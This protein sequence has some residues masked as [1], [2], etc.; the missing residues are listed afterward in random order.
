[1]KYEIKCLL[2][3]FLKDRQF[4]ESSIIA[5]SMEFQSLGPNA[6]TCRFIILVLANGMWSFDAERV[7]WSCTV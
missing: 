2:Y 3:R 7:E 1:M 5:E 6:R 4:L